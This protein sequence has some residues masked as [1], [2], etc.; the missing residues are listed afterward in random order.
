MSKKERVPHVMIVVPSFKIL[1][2]VANH[3]MGLGKYWKR[4]AVKYVT[5]GKRRF[6][7]AVATLLPDLLFFVL[8]LILC[9]VDI[10]VVNPSLRPYQLTRDGVYLRLAKF[11]GKKVVTFIH[12]WDDNVMAQ[13]ESSPARFLSTYGKSDLIYV[14]CS[15]FCD[16]LIRA[17][18]DSNRIHLT[19]TKVDDSLIKN[20]DMRLRD[21]HVDSILFM[22]RADKPK[23]LD[24]TIKAYEILRRQ[25]PFLCLDVCGTGDQLEWAKEYVAKKQIEGV[26]FAG[27]VVGDDRIRHFLNSQ[28]YILPTTHG[29]GMAT[30]VLEAMTMGMVVITRPMGGVKDFF[31]NG[32]H[33]FITESLDAADYACIIQNLIDNRDLVAQIEAENQRYGTERFLASAVASRLEDDFLTLCLR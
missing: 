8:R 3:Y 25:N 2:G 1:G 5:Y 23:G 10:V 9:R 33:G 16:A 4:V 24:I 26:S 17:G 12:G 21:G 22:A 6:F 14:L 29:E 28:V 18:I 11:F 13:I 30:S 32:H 20:L 15:D 27:F 31:V 7:P 19:T